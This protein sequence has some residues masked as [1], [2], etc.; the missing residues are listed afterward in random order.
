MKVRIQVVIEA[1]DGKSEQVQEIARLERGSL[2][3]EELGLTLAEAKVVLHGMH[4]G[5]GH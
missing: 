3:Q 1:E 5:H 2:R 4:A